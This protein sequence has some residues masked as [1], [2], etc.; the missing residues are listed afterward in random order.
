[1]GG[2]YSYC[3]EENRRNKKEEDKEE[4]KESEPDEGDA[5][6]EALDI[7]QSFGALREK[8][9]AKGAFQVGNFDD[10]ISLAE[11]IDEA[12]KQSEPLFSKDSVTPG[13]PVENLEVLDIAAGFG[14]P[15]DTNED[16]GD[17]D[18][19]S[20]EP[21]E[22]TRDLTRKS[23][24]PAAEEYS[25]IDENES[26]Q[27]PVKLEPPSSF[28]IDV[29]GKTEPL[30]VGHIETALSL[31]RG[32]SDFGDLSSEPL[33]ELLLTVFR[34][35]R[36][37]V[38]IIKRRQ[39]VVRLFVFEG[40]VIVSETSSKECGLAIWMRDEGYIDNQAYSDLLRET[41]SLNT[42]QCGA[43]VVSRGIL[44][45]RE[46]NRLI[47][48][49]YEYIVISAMAWTGGTWRFEKSARVSAGDTSV[50]IE[51]TTPSLI[52]QGINR[53]AK[54]SEVEAM[55]PKWTSLRQTGGGECRLAD[56]EI[57][58]VERAILGACDGTDDI[59]K[60]IVPHSLEAERY[61]RLLAAFWLLGF[62]EIA[63]DA[64]KEN[65]GSVDRRDV[66]VPSEG[67]HVSLNETNVG[68]RECA[69]NEY[70]TPQ[71]VLGMVKNKLE[72]VKEGSYFDVLEV[73]PTASRA[74]IEN[75]RARLLSVF[76]LEKISGL[77][78]IDLDA[79]VQLIRYIL[80]EAYEVLTHPEIGGKYREVALQQGE[81]KDRRA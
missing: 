26:E 33:Y 42:L 66:P 58:D 52:F 9:V 13:A 46:M 72:T 55:I 43:A 15:D 65:Q 68:Q 64:S 18:S 6:K 21:S 70:H 12:E 77:G 7:A 81:V 34:E 20:R 4:K 48:K 49:Y 32:K 47:R 22:N 79:D 61:H 36:T 30:K 60:R 78:L 80:E 3:M 71:E 39:T 19:Q 5:V 75:A 59:W 23:K 44:G 31:P 74:D 53:Y 54:M 62:L 27:T 8:R 37:G 69:L 25:S 67:E 57:D 24:I 16:D 14:R 73:A 41:S 63:N 2:R 10:S 45:P 51:S 1:M 38:L 11:Y 35:K 29:E 40:D 50:M 56:L 76:S 28:S 17:S